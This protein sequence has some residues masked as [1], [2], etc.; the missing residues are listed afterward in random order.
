MDYLMACCLVGESDTISMMLVPQ[1]VPTKKDTGVM[2][3]EVTL[4]MPRRDSGRPGKRRRGRHLKHRV[5]M[6]R[7]G[8]ELR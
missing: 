3:L 4:L 6:R 1:P 8:L 7:S 5:A 2:M